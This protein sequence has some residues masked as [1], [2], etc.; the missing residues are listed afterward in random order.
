M[1]SRFAIS[2]MKPPTLRPRRGRTETLQLKVTLRKDMKN[3]DNFVHRL[4]T[5]FFCCK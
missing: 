1:A 2:L 3:H 4:E 5:L